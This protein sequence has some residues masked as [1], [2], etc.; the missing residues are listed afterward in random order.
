MSENWRADYLTEQER[1]RREEARIAAEQAR[2]EREAEERAREKA[3]REREEARIAKEKAEAERKAAAEAAEKARIARELAE[4]AEAKAREECEKAARVAEEAQRELEEIA[5]MKEELQQEREELA[6]K[7]EEERRAQEEAARIAEEKARIAAD[8]AAKEAEKSQR[9]VANSVT[10]S[11]KNLGFVVKEP[12][13]EGESLKILALKP[14]GAKAEFDV[15][16]GGEMQY[17][18]HNYAADKSADYEGQKCKK[19]IAEVERLLEEC[20]SVKLSGKK[21]LWEANPD[22]KRKGSKELPTG[23]AEQTTSR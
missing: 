6:K 20:Y 10:L 1:Q 16:L 18:L 19:D 8:E 14:S 7:A 17:K 12:E 4:K 21:L 15:K 9:E 2:R 11:L 3:R 5:R 23:G 13:A 22:R